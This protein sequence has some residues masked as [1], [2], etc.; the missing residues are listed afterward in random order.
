MVVTNHPWLHGKTLHP[1]PSRNKFRNYVE[2]WVQSRNT[3]I[4][5]FVWIHVLA[6]GKS[7]SVDACFLIKG[8]LKFLSRCVLCGYVRRKH[9]TVLA[10]TSTWNL[11]ISE[12]AVGMTV[13]DT[14]L[15]MDTPNTFFLLHLHT[16]KK[17][18]VT[19][20]YLFWLHPWWSPFTNLNGLCAW[21]II[22]I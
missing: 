7:C 9:S 22:G 13:E 11:P 1:N 19:R 16:C 17:K 4:I 15:I 6:W 18:K 8:V 14:Y 3:A 10:R 20:M 21:N 2:T 12:E 5:T